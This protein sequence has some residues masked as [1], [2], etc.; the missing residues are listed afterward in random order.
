MLFNVS[1]KRPLSL[2][3]IISVFKLPKFWIFVVYVLGT[4]RFYNIYDLQLTT[5]NSRLE[6]F[7]QGLQTAGLK[8]NSDWIV[9]ADYNENIGYELIKAVHHKLGRLPKAIFTP[10]CNILQEILSYLVEI[11]AKQDDISLCS[12]DYNSYFDLICYPIDAIAQDYATMAKA[13]VNA[14]NKLINFKPLKNS[15][16]FIK[17]QIVWRKKRAVS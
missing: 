12:Y 7:K 6:G 15:Q 11:N 1:E 3:E 17:P 9:S 2:Q 5:I 10:S 13:C 16:I 14:T 8:L 4:Y